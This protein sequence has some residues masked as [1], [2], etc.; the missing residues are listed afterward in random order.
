MPLQA[1]TGDDEL[2]RQEAL[3]AAAAAWEAAGDSVREVHHGDELTSAERGEAVAESCRT[4]DLF[5]PRKLL[6]VRN[7]DKARA[8]AVKIMLEAFSAPVD[9]VLVLLE[10]EK[11]DGRQG[12]VQA[13]KKSGNLAEFKLPYGDKIP[14]WLVER[15][16]AQYG[17]ALGLPEAGLMFEIVGGDTAELD[18]E[19]QKLDTFLPK[20][21]PISAEAIRDVV[22]PLKQHTIFE[23]QKAAG[24]ADLRAFLPALRSLLDEQSGSGAGIGPVILL[25]NHFLRLARIRSLLDAGE[26]EQAIVDATKVNSFIYRKEGYAEQ[27][28]RRSLAVWKRVLARL[29]EL[30]REMKTGRHAE[31]FEIETALAGVVIAGTARRSRQSQ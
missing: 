11:L 24:H 31:R 8:E 22:S 30:E 3:E 7:F 27:A 28:R 19:L 12:W 14:A 16:R 29:A 5:A 13:L 2:R 25:F 17:R 9:T 10:A 1:F 20:G 26:S 15:A 21:A 18:Q 23:L 6:I 4:P